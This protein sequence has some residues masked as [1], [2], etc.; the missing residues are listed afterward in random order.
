MRVEKTKKKILILFIALSMVIAKTG[1]E[2]SLL[3]VASLDM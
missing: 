3:C 1:S 2:E